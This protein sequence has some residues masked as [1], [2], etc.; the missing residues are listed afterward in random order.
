MKIDYTLS[1][2]V[3][4]GVIVFGCV[5]NAQNEGMES[6]EFYMLLGTIRTGSL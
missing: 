4:F 2:L 5:Q 6:N 3:V 1:M